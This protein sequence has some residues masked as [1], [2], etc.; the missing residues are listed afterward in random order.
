MGISNK[1]KMTKMPSMTSS[2][3]MLF[4]HVPKFLSPF[5]PPL[6][7]HRALFRTPLV[8]L[9]PPSC[10]SHSFLQNLHFYFSDL[11]SWKFGP[12]PSHIFV[13]HYGL[14]LRHGN[15]RGGDR[16]YLPRPHTRF[17]YTYS[18]PYLYPTGIRNWITSPS[19]MGSGISPHPRPC[20][21]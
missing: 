7:P 8:V 16:F 6:Q 13:G 12:Q 5:Q 18:L 9:T 4:I 17:S 3:Q 19:P 14:P 15:G 11:T 20:I 21:E 1:S 2:S 10:S